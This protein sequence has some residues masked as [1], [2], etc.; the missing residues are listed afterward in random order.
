MT[1]LLE[2]RA[3]SRHFTGGDGQPFTVLDSL[4]IAIAP[5]EFV[6]IVGASGS[7][8]STLLHLLG[9]LDRPDGGEVR[10][11]GVAYSGLSPKALARLR[12]A[13]L[14]FVFQF[15]H[16]LRDFSAVENVEM[17]LRIAGEPT[18]RAR[19]RARELLA[20]LGLAARED[21]R[22]TVLSGGEQQ[23]VALARALAHRPAVLLADEPTGNLDPP[24]A[25]GLHDL[26]A[27]LPGN[28]ETALVVVTHNRDLAARADRI[29]ALEAGR[30]RAAD[31]TELVP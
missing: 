4:D 10:L 17:P 23:R 3:L 26:L 28:Q 29:L 31:T 11:E 13:R 16:L 18:D 2:G 20:S 1:A 25:E 30:L 22:V 19:A 21:S 15:H 14:G 6:A 5:R 9:A 7:G 8:K 24:T 27:A 12:N